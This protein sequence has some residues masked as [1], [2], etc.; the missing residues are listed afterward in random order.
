MTY[1]MKIAE[2]RDEAKNEERT[3]TALDMLRENE[4]IEKIIKYSHLSKERIEQLSMQLSN[5]IPHAP[6]L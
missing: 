6:V 4:P 5:S 3:S 2:E 1:Q